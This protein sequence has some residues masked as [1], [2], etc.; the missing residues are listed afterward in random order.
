MDIL[1][2]VGMLGSKPISTPSD[3][4]T[5]LHQHLGNLLSIE[6][7]SSFRRLIGRLIYLTNTRP[8]ITYVVQHLSQFIATPTSVYQQAAF[9]ILR[10]LKGTPGARIFLSAASNIHLKG[11]SDSDWAGCIDTQ[12]SITGYVVYI[13][14]SLISWKSKKQATMSR[15]SSEAEYRALASA[16]CELQWLTYLLEEFKIDF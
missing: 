3:Y 2:D 8:N 5:K 9:W 6:N 13:G 14:N 15:S 4:T 1:S 10:Y 16:T 12:R 11:F 7:A